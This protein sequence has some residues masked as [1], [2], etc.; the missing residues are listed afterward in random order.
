MTISVLQVSTPFDDA[1]S[2]STIIN[3][4]IT[5]SAGSYLHAIFTYSL[6]DTLT[7][8]TSSPSLTWSILD[9]IDDTTN[10]QT[11][12]H[13]ISSVTSAG[14]ITVTGN[15]S[16]S[17]TFRGGIVKEIG[18]SSGYDTGSHAAQLQATPTT[19]TDATTSTNTPSLSAQPA[20]ISGA[21]MNTAGVATP[22]AGTG[23]ASDSSGFGFGG[24]SAMRSENM[25][26]T[27]TSAVA[28]TFTAGNNSAHISLAA[29]FLESGG[30]GGI[31]LQESEWHPMEPQ[32][33]PTTVSVW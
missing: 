4:A 9:A 15:L 2:S 13:A 27:S 17:D 33:N 1:T 24:T 7:S 31:A 32:T 16:A 5:V 12:S 29:V 21:C 6:G 25:R 28:A 30:G 8:V 22:A 10:G 14:S 20:L 26:V 3:N 18:G 23:F 11:F 19:G